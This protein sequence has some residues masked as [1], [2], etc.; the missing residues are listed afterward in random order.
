MSVDLKKFKLLIVEDDEMMRENL[1]EFF[2][3]EG[4]NVFSA[5]NGEE[6]LQIAL[7]ERVDLILSDIK[8]PVMNGVELLKAIYA[9]EK[10]IPIVWLMTGQSDLTEEKAIEMGAEGIINKPF[11]LQLVKEKISKSLEKKSKL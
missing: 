6:A 4:A 8:M 1:C 2:Q 7:V 9:N 10:I 3:G 11:K 5:N